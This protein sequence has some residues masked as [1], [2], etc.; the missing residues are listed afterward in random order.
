MLQ[1]FRDFDRALIHEKYKKVLTKLQNRL[2]PG[3]GE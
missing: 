3:E 2:C 1:G